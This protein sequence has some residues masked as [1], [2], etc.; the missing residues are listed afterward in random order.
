MTYYY[1][2]TLSDFFQLHKIGCFNNLKRVRSSL[3]YIETSNLKILLIVRFQFVTLFH[4][5][6]GRFAQSLHR[7]MGSPLS[8]GWGVSSFFETFGFLISFVFS[9]PW[10]LSLRVK[11]NSSNLFSVHSSVTYVFEIK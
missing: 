1:V 4:T 9:Y 2:G 8:E 6:G 3:L 7:C 11:Q 10:A 5:P